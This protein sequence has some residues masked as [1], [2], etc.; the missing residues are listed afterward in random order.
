MT[1]INRTPANKKPC[2]L[3][4][5]LA[6]EE[7]EGGVRIAALREKA[8]TVTIPREIEGMPVVALGSG[9]FA[10]QETLEEIVLPDTLREVGSFAFAGCRALRV[11][12]L[13]DSVE[14]LGSHMIQDTAITA[15][16]LPRGVTALPVGVFSYC[17]GLRTVVLHDGLRSIGAHAFFNTR[18]GEAEPLVLPDSVEKIEAGAFFSVS[19]PISVKTALPTD[20]FWTSDFPAPHDPK[21]RLSASINVKACKVLREAAARLAPVSAEMRLLRELGFITSEE[22]QKEVMTAYAANLHPMREQLAALRKEQGAAWSEEDFRYLNDLLLQSCGLRYVFRDGD[23]KV[24]LA[25]E[26]DPD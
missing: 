20:P 26:K 16:T 14:V 22:A 19:G 12:D 5:T 7:C 9:C 2:N 1:Q 3:F 15:F 23:V 11:L 4:G 6:W 21:D 18:V 10:G 8:F 24:G 25:E 17:K 13:P